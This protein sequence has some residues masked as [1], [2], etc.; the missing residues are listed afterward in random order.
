MIDKNRFMTRKEIINELNSL[1]SL[2][3][4]IHILT[5]II[6]KDFTVSDKLD[7]S[8]HEK[9]SHNEISFL[10]GLWLKN[11]KNQS[12]T[13]DFETHIDNIYLLMKQLHHTLT[14]NFFSNLQLSDD[15]HKNT[16]EDGEL[17][18]ESIF[19]AD[20]GAYDY[21]NIIF[22]I[23]KYKY[24]RDWL[25]N[26]KNFDIEII[27]YFYNDL[28]ILMQN[29]LNNIWW[30]EE[31]ASYDCILSLFCIN[32]IEL[33]TTLNKYTHIID[34]LT[35]KLGSNCNS[36][37]NNIGDINIYNEKPIIE[38][39]N[40]NLFI[41]NLFLIS[42]ALYEAPYYW[43]CDDT[44]Y[45][46]TA[47]KNRGHA[48]EEIVERLMLPIFGKKNIFK[49]IIISRSRSNRITDIDIM[50]VYNNIAI[51]FQV[52]SKRLTQLSKQGNLE[53]IK[54]DFKI[55]VENAFIQGQKV[56]ECIKYFDKYKFLTEPNNVIDSIN[57]ITSTYIV[58][59]VLDNFPGITHMSKI[60]LEEKYREQPLA[61]SIFD[62]DMIVK[63]L[64]NKDTF[65]NYIKFRNDNANKTVANNEMDYLVFFLD[66]DKF[67]LSAQDF[68]VLD[69]D[70]AT[71]L[72]NDY[73]SEELKKGIL[74]RKKK[75]TGRNEQCPCLSGK[76]YKYCHGKA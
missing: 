40:G 12:L 74:N 64:Q 65:V 39:P 29:K 16:L 15:A 72:D 51:V 43:M 36:D 9:M 38:L 42:I 55:A 53:S 2:D 17:L 24:D 75:G 26:N 28:K 27:S 71:Q 10:I 68:V 62:L 14:S 73:H 21:Q 56:R 22:A 31:D 54:N 6:L 60:F 57:K 52:K 49:N 3:S 30:K 1:T 44:L 8:V 69:N 34:A 70:W 5:Y 61:I 7:N 66:K 11:Y 58:T 45:K 63:Y 18:Q 19:Y 33:S 67:D 59:I 25:L 13:T 76:K 4:F 46:D 41:P 32:K 23:N 37:F 20:T 35:V 48:A 47:L 50:A